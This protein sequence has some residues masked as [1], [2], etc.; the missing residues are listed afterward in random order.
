[1]SKQTTHGVHIERFDHNKLNEIEGKTQ[2]RVEISNMFAASE[3]LGTEV[4]IN[5]AVTID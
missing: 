3:N 1:V 4:D 2:Y 5:R